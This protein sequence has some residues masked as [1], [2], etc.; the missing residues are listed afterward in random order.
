KSAY[1]GL[2]WTVGY[3][4]VVA[5]VYL[6]LPGLIVT[7]FEGG[8][9]PDDFAAVAAIVPGLLTCVAA[10]SLADA[11]CVTFGF[12]LRGAGDTWFVTIATF[13]LAWP[14]MVIPTALV[15]QTGGS[16][17]WAWW[18]ATGHVFAM[19]LCFYLR[20]RTGKWKAMRVIEPALEAA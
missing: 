5:L 8:R 15:V 2:K 11:F 1:T 16:V 12:A 17:N 14:I 19:S 7:V 18:F 4:T 20:F 6:T 13:C 9:D 3:M 10:Y